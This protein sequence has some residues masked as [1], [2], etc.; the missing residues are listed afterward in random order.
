MSEGESG[1]RLRRGPIVIKDSPS[2]E[3][4]TPPA[5][6]ATRPKL[7]IRRDPDPKLIIEREQRFINTNNKLVIGPE[8][9]VQTGSTRKKSKLVITYSPKSKVVIK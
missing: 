4:V 8:S 1:E 7:V 5:S 2:T 6:Q 3:A 9:T